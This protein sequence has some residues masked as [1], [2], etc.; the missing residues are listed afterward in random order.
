[1]NNLSIVTHAAT[2]AFKEFFD[3]I[4]VFIKLFFLTALLVLIVGITTLGLGLPFLFFYITLCYIKVSYLLYQQQ[5]VTLRQFFIDWKTFIKGLAAL[6]LYTILVNIGLI[7]FII[8]GLYLAS[9][10]YYI[11]YCIVLDKSSITESFHCSDHLTK[12]ARWH[13]LL[14]LLCATILGA[15]IIFL[16]VAALM[17]VHAYNARKKLP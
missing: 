5:P 11:E 1:M 10:Y 6:I 16:P 2:W 17:N 12:H 8:P 7:L 3:H 9:R 4:T 13:G 14:L 15:T